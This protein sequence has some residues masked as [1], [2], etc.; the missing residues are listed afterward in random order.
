MSPLLKYDYGA[1]AYVQGNNGFYYYSAL[2]YAVGEE[3]QKL[4]DEYDCP[5]YIPDYSCHAF[6]STNG[7]RVT[8]NLQPLLWSDMLYELA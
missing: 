3:S 4:T 8:E 2:F 6:D 1:V 7:F 5:D